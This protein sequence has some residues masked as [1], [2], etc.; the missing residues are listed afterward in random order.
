MAVLQRSGPGPVQRL[1]VGMGMEFIQP[2]LQ[3][4]W[5]GLKLLVGWL[6]GAACWLAARAAA[7]AMGMCRGRG[8]CA[9]LGVQIQDPVP[10]NRPCSTASRAH[11]DR[12]SNLNPYLR[13]PL[14]ARLINWLTLAVETP[15]S[16]A[17]AVMLM[18]DFRFAISSASSRVGQL[19]S[20]SIKV[21]GALRCR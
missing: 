17:S 13:S 19:A 8:R 4:S 12:V 16:A 3:I 6:V 7:R 18:P 20:Q 5:R 10:F 1:A 11:W 14:S 21:S 15:S 2:L 9:R